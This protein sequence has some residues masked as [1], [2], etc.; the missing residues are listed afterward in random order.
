[1]PKDGVFVAISIQKAIRGKRVWLVVP[2]KPA[3][4]KKSGKIRYNFFVS[5][6]LMLIFYGPK[7]CEINV[8]SDGREKTSIII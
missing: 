7:I 8:K 3:H 4:L 5:S 2:L 1:M 6:K